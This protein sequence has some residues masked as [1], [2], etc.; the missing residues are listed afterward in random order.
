MHH[1]GA[2]E[3]SYSKVP[4]NHKNHIKIESD[5]KLERETSL[6]KPLLAMIVHFKIKVA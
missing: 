1:K 4:T 5:A 2:L 3:Q 6:E